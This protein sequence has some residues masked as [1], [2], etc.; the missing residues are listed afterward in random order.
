M[1]PNG[2]I[3]LRE[4]REDDLLFFYGMYSSPEVM[5]YTFID[6]CAEY[7]DYLP[8]FQKSMRDAAAVH[9]VRF[10]YVAELNGTRVGMGD[11][12]THGQAGSAEIGYMLLPQYWGRGYAT[13]IAHKLLA[14]GFTDMG[15]SRMFACCNAHNAASERVMQKCGMRLESVGVGARYKNGTWQDELCYA[16]SADEWRGLGARP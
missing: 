1:E 12:D 16:I 15:L 7:K 5:R 10:E 2:E 4:I 8:Y 3:R 6:A 9:R 13:Q 14:A 11:I